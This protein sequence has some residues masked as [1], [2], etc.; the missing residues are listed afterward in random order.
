MPMASANGLSAEPRAR[1]STR[2]RA[3]VAGT[4]GDGNRGPLGRV[5]A[6]V[7]SDLR[8]WWLVAARPMSLRAWRRALRPTRVPDDNGLLRG[9]WRFDNLT[10][11]LVLRVLSIGLLLAG[12]A[13]G[14]LSCHPLRRWGALGCAAGVAA[15]L[16]I[17]R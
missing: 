7:R 14:W 16:L 15:W 13:V 11:G 5:V 9:L 6:A 3:R 1:E 17:G 12:G 10:T 4:D 8:R 2:A